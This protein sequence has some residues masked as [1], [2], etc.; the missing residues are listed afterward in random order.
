MESLCPS[1]RMR[2]GN[3]GC[4]SFLG[5]ASGSRRMG[6]WVKEGQCVRS[7]RW[8]RHGSRGTFRE[9]RINMSHLISIKSFLKCQVPVPKKYEKHLAPK[10]T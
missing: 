2:P 8:P 1:E 10:S 5:V 7:D 9:A 3:T 6:E 4:I